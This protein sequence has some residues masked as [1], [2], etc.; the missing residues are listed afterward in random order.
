M[1][2][3]IVIFNKSKYSVFWLNHKSLLFQDQ[4]LFALSS[5]CIWVYNYSYWFFKAQ[6]IKK[7]RF[8]K[9]LPMLICFASNMCVFKMG[10]MYCKNSKWYVKGIHFNF[11]CKSILISTTDF[12]ADLSKSNT[13]QKYNM[14]TGGYEN[15]G[16]T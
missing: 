5:I 1:C 11:I 10:Y 12:S 2:T 14:N 7:N 6:E 13:I 16:Q 4:R 8:W 9:S 15:N 3:Q